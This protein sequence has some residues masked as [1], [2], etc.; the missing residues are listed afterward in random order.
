MP[1]NRLQVWWIISQKKRLELPTISLP[2]PKNFENKLNLSFRSLKTKF[3]RCLNK[4]L[5]RMALK[6]K[7]LWNCKACFSEQSID[8][9][10][11]FSILEEDRLAWENVIAK[12]KNLTQ[13]KMERFIETLVEQVWAISTITNNQEDVRNLKYKK[14][15]FLKL[16]CL[17]DRNHNPEQFDFKWPKASKFDVIS[18]RKRIAINKIKIF[19]NSSQIWFIKVYLSNGK[20]SEDTAYTD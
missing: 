14:V 10:K 17:T 20:N 3:W 16:S 6:E 9:S 7:D 4:G 8:K 19:H 2:N 5:K 11:F 1:S 13:K 18:G 12:N 15:S